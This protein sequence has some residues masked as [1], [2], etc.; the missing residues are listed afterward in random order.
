MVLITY[1]VLPEGE[2]LLLAEG[3][4]I[5]SLPIFNGV[6]GVACTFTELWNDKTSH[7]RRITCTE[8]LSARRITIEYMEGITGKSCKAYYMSGYSNNINQMVIR[9][10]KVLNQIVRDFKL[11]G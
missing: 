10:V 2:V 1:K 3:R 6:T 7:G 8:D 9:Y 4:M 5:S 11:K